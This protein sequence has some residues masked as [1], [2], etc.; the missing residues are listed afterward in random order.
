MQALSARIT[1]CSTGTATEKSL[2]TASYAHTTAPPASRPRPSTASTTQHA[3]LYLGQA[4]S[5]FPRDGPTG[6]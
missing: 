1:T 3:I 6:H 5:T 4:I 2:P